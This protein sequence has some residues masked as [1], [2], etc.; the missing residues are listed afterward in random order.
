MHWLHSAFTGHIGLTASGG[1][2]IMGLIFGWLRGK[3]GGLCMFVAIVG[4]S[5]GPNFIDGLESKGIGLYLGKWLFR[6]NTPVLL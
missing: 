4:I 3:T 1:A 5:S 6:F 2:L